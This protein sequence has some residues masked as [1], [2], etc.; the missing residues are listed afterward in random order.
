MI[1]AVLVPTEDLGGV[2]GRAIVDDQDLLDRQGLGED[3]V[4]RFSEVLATVVTGHDD[5]DGS[6]RTAG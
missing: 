6:L 3:G 4:E 5:A 1:R 2:I